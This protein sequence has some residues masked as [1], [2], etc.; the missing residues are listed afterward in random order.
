[1]VSL[2]IKKLNEQ[3][4][5]NNHCQWYA[6]EDGCREYIF[7]WSNGR[8]SIKIYPEPYAKMDDDGNTVVGVN[9][10]ITPAPYT[11]EEMQTEEFKLASTFFKVK[12]KN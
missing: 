9:W 11:P 7:L 10:F 12:E 2:L 5:G 4:P 3:C 8:T 1:M 6:E